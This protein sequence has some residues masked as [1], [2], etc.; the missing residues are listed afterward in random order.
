[1]RSFVGAA[2]IERVAFGNE[3]LSGSRRC[4]GASAEGFPSP[5]RERDL[6][7][8]GYIDWTVTWPHSQGHS[9]QRPGSV[10]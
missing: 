2:R 1:M 9:K 10:E 4:P 6:I 3:L 5:T 8:A 7:S